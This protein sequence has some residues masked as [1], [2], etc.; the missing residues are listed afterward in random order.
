VGSKGACAGYDQQSVPYWYSQPFCGTEKLVL[1]GNPHGKSF[2]G[3]GPKVLS[4]FFTEELLKKNHE[5]AR[6]FCDCRGVAA[7]GLNV[8]HAVHPSSFGGG[9]RVG[10]L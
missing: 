4:L 6:R 8:G 1:E 10:T 9:K 2:L 7:T 5:D 3:E